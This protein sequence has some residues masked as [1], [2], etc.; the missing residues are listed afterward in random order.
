MSNNSQTTS[1]FDIG[2]EDMMDKCN[3]LLKQF[4]DALG[5]RY[6]V[7]DWLGAYRTWLDKHIIRAD[8]GGWPSPEAFSQI[9]VRHFIKEKLDDRQE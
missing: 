9:N 4:N 2:E 7:G 3:K 5:E 6:T 8:V 1:I